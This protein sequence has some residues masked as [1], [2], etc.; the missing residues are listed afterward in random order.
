[1]GWSVSS[2]WVESA[3]PGTTFELAPAEARGC[4]V[5]K[6]GRRLVA[7]DPVLKAQDEARLAI[8][9]ARAE[10]DSCGAR[11][12]VMPHAQVEARPVRR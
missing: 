5:S 12:D 11:S 1:M 7:C 3:K 6:R 10:C 4:A 9:P 8:T 2:G